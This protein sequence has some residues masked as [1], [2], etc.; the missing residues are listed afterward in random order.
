VE[1]SVPEVGSP[2]V[3]SPEVGSPEAGSPEVGSPEIGSPEVGSSEIGSPEVGSPEVGSP[4][5]GS[6]EVGSHEA[7]SPE[8]GSHEGESLKV[9][10]LPAILTAQPC[11]VTTQYLS[12]GGHGCLSIHST[13]RAISFSSFSRTPGIASATLALQGPQSLRNCGVFGSFH[14]PTLS[15]WAPH[16]SHPLLS[17]VGVMGEVLRATLVPC[18]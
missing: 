17:A 13:A 10:S 7:G 18:W 9:G 16:R 8:V 14:G 5:A 12:G 1:A 15:F 2:E 4:E 6:P 11:S 3:G